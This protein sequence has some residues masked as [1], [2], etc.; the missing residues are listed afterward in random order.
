MNHLTLE[1]PDVHP[2]LH[3]YVDPPLTHDLPSFAFY[4]GLVM[5]PTLVMPA[6]RVLPVLAPPSDS[7]VSMNHV[8]TPHFVSYRWWW[9]SWSTRGMDSANGQTVLGC[10]RARAS[11]LFNDRFTYGHLLITFILDSHNSIRFQP[12]HL[13]K[14]LSSPLPSG[15]NP[16]LSPSQ[17]TTVLHRYTP[18][19][20]AVNAA[21]IANLKS[22]HNR[23]SFSS[24]DS[25]DVSDLLSSS[26]SISSVG[27]GESGCA[28]S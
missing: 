7:R 3:V 26:F 28:V 18:S 8:N 23:L 15:R 4:P 24:A 13:K 5:C 11:R 6:I 25:T 9:R 20:S 2:E 16:P 21:I 14:F 12:T 10:L 19:R 17:Q 1:L 22:D 27:F